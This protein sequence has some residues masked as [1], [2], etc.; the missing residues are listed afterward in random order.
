VHTERDQPADRLNGPRSPGVNRPGAAGAHQTITRISR[1]LEE[2]VYHPGATYAE[3]T[4][5]L[6][7]PKS[8]VYGF[9]RGLLAVGWL[10][11]RDHRLYLGPAFYSLAIAS[12]HIRAGSVTAAELDALH[13]EAGLIASVGVRAGDHLIYIAEAG[14]DLIT[15]FKAR[16][17]IRRGLLT[18]AGGKALLAFMP[19][20]EVEAYLRRRGP[21]DREDVDAFL[22]ACPAIRETGVAVNVIDRRARTGIGMVIRDSTGRPVASVTLSGPTS[23]VLPRLGTLSELLRQRVEAWRDRST[24]A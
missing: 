22:E 18:T 9:I 4:R 23:Q 21:E 15:D 12:G 19:E 13:R 7:A 24:A 1:I 10:F 6:G 3:L 14:N 20:G 17:A 16:S 11:E 5:A 8:S 2:V